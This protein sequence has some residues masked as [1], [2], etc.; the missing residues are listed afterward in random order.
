MK[1]SQYSL[2]IIHTIVLVDFQ[3]SHYAGVHLYSILISYSTTIVA[4]QDFHYVREYWSLAFIL[5]LIIIAA[6]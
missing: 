5:Y 3:D 4:F 2:S 6:L 1:M